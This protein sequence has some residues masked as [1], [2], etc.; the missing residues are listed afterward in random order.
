MNL[1]GLIGKARVG[2]DA[3]AARLYRQHDFE[4]TSFA[5]PMKQMLAAAFPDVNF[6]NGDREAPL[7]WL[8]KSPRQLMQTLGT[9]WGRE[10]IH[11][12]LWTVLAERQIQKARERQFHGLVLSDVRFKNEAAM[13][14]RNGGQL[15][16]IERDTA[17][18]VNDHLS[19]QCDWSD[20]PRARINNNGSIAELYSNIDKLVELLPNKT[21]IAS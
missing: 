20:Y 2:K 18:V 16:H 10:C 13:I 14:L 6:Y 3:V 7:D 8:G 9:E 12:D 15:W 1:I 19:E 17:Q 11:P 4:Q 21:R 5:A